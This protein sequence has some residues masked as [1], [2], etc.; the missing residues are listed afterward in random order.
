MKDNAISNH[1]FPKMNTQ[2][3]RIKTVHHLDEYP[4]VDFTLN[5]H[6]SFRRT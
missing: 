5:R 3:D 1:I 4:I 6:V 2:T